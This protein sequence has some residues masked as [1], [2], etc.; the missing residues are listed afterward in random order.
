M[1]DTSATVQQKFAPG[2]AHRQRHYDTFSRLHR[3]RLHALRT[4]LNL[5]IGTYG[6]AM[7]AVAAFA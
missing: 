4:G 5:A 2:T 1:S 7:T 6:T 3:L